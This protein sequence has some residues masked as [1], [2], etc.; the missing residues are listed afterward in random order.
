MKHLYALV[1]GGEIAAVK[2]MD[3]EEFIKQQRIAKEATDG[4]DAWYQVSEL[5]CAP[6][7]GICAVSSAA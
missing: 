1:D 2:V 3:G 6:N 5:P 4:N 7:L